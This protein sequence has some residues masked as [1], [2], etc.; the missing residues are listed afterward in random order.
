MGANTDQH[1]RHRH[2]TCGRPGWGHE[3]SQGPVGDLGDKC[4][5]HEKNNKKKKQH[6]KKKLFFFCFFF[7]AIRAFCDQGDCIDHLQARA[8]ING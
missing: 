5:L 4:G 8:L 6:K 1:H 7:L 3:G 2:R